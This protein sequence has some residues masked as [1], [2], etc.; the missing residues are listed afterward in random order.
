MLGLRTDQRGLFEAD[1]LYLDCVAQNSFYGFL[2][3]QRGQLFS[4]K[5]SDD[6]AK[7]RADF[8]L[9]H[10]HKRED[11]ITTLTKCGGP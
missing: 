7:T 8:F 10:R 2:A 6:E 9:L 3:C 11:I 5:V 1:H 4:D